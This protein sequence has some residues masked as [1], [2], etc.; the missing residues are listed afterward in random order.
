MF[1]HL[2]SLGYILP[3]VISP[4]AYISKRVPQH[5]PWTLHEEKNAGK[6]DS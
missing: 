3:T 4:K 5:E 6:D 2:T 1:N